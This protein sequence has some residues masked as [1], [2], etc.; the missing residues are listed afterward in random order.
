M[1][2]WKWSFSFIISPHQ[3][4]G[5]TSPFPEGITISLLKKKHLYC[6]SSQT[7]AKAA[8][9]GCRVSTFGDIQNPTGPGPDYFPPRSSCKQG[10]G[11]HDLPAAPSCLTTLWFSDLSISLSPL[12]VFFYNLESLAL[13]RWQGWPHNP[14]YTALWSTLPLCSFDNLVHGNFKGN[15]TLCKKRL[16][17]KDFKY[18]NGKLQRTSCSQTILDTDSSQSEPSKTMSLRLQFTLPTPDTELGL[19]RFGLHCSGA[20][21]SE[22][23]GFPCRMS[24][25]NSTFSIEHRMDWRADGLRRCYSL[26]LG[27]QRSDTVTESY[28]AAT[29]W[30]KLKST[31]KGLDS[32]EHA[33]KKLCSEQQHASPR[34]LYT[35]RD[36]HQ[37]EGSSERIQGAL[38]M[39]M[40]SSS[41]FNLLGRC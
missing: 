17:I 3:V 40:P 37:P 18:L 12:M 21:F 2:N 19:Q 29:V 24:L 5:T 41:S 6:H 16:S 26:Y 14:S 36:V 7:A 15:C 35:P 11:L 23:I 32:Y 39:G 10:A 4:P 1:Q 33:S 13:F 20:G 38:S 30:I 31:L 28:I 22:I 27:K 34:S 25:S 9:R 8:Q